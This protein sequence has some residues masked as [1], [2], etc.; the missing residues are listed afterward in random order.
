VKVRAGAAV[1]IALAV[2]IGV[3]ACA[4]I[5]SLKKYDPSDG[6]SANV[7]QVKVL[8][9]LVL[10]KAGATGNLLFSAYNNSDELVQLTVQYTVG[11]VKQTK[12]ASVL[13]DA[14]SNFG[15]TSKTEFLLPGIDT[16]AGSLLP[17]YFQYGSEEGK[18]IDVPVLD[19]S[20]PQYSKLLPTPTPTPTATTKPVLPPPVSP[21]SPTPSATAGA[22]TTN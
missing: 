14:T 19:G 22:T 6:V 18:R 15:Y 17:I 8:N 13:P 10:T 9:A 12:T 21:A 5:S 3:A 1:A 7:G 11:G 2:T 4:P 16:K 20:L